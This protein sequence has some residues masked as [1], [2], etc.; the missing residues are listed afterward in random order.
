[1]AA[2][3]YL[4]PET[5]D[6]H[7]AVSDED[8]DRVRALLSSR[9]GRRLVNRN[10]RYLSTPLSYAGG[11]AE[12]VQLLLGNGA[13]PH[14]RGGL[15]Y[16]TA[17]HELAQDGT[18]EVIDIVLGFGADVHITDANG[19]TPL[20]YAAERRNCDAA[21]ALLDAG[22]DVNQRDKWKYAPLHSAMDGYTRDPKAKIP[23]A[24]LLLDRGAQV[25]A[26]TKHG[27]TALSI[28][29]ANY[30]DNRLVFSSPSEVELL[31]DRGANVHVRPYGRSLLQQLE[32]LA[33]RG[34]PN[35]K[36]FVQLLRA[37]GAS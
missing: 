31:L 17:F 10:N 2:W 29:I 18:K 9:S 1:L 15:E 37:R 35:A 19:R 12:I 3:L 4:L 33:E 20:H 30:T 28:A 11:C 23:I 7:D 34:F 27:K 32:R 36:K 8:I 21:A 14:S 25:N 24:N 13:N 26:V 5:T 6:L 16:E 22:A